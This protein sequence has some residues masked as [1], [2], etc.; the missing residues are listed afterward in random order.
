VTPG[1]QAPLGV[2]MSLPRRLALGECVC[3]GVRHPLTAYRTRSP[4][5]D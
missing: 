4:S 3:H 5:V 1:Q 2:T